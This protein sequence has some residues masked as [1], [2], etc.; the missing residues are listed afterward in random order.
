MY[1]CRQK[2]PDSLGVPIVLS[3]IIK[4][5]TFSIKS[6]LKYNWNWP[7]N[8]TV[9]WLLIYKKSQE[10]KLKIISF[11]VIDIGYISWNSISY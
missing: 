1:T 2:V 10:S 5:K 4:K 3:N 9:T 11:K 6:I 7:N 8:E